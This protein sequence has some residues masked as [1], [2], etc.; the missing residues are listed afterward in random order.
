MEQPQ[1]LSNSTR[2]Y[3]KNIKNNDVRDIQ[4]S[5]YA[6]YINIE[7]SKKIK[8]N[9]IRL[10]NDLAALQREAENNRKNFFTQKGTIKRSAAYFSQ[11]FKHFTEILNGSLI[12]STTKAPV[13]KVASDFKRATKDNFSALFLHLI[14]SILGKTNDITLTN[15]KT[16]LRI[17]L[18]K[19]YIQF[20]AEYGFDNIKMEQSMWFQFSD[21]I[22]HSLEKAGIVLVC[23]KLG[24]R[25]KK[26]K[27]DYIA[28]SEAFKSV[29]IVYDYKASNMPLISKPRDWSF[30]DNVG[31]VHGGFLVGKTDLIVYN[32]EKS[33]MTRVGDEILS[34]INYLQ[35]I[36]YKINRKYLREIKKDFSRFLLEKGFTIHNYEDI[37]DFNIKSGVYSERQGFAIYNEE[38]RAI[39]KIIETIEQSIYLSNFPCF[40]FAMYLD[41]RTR[42]YYHSYPLNPQGD[43]LSRELLMF[44]NQRKKS[45]THSLDVSASG[46]QII[47][48]LLSHAEYLKKTNF[49]KNNKEIVHEKRDLY[50]ETLD[51]YLSEKNFDNERYKQ[52][53][54]NFF[55]RKVFKSIIMCYFYNETHFGV[56]KKLEALGRRQRE[57]LGFNVNIE[58]TLIRK[59]LKNEFQE[60]HLLAQII[61]QCVESS[62]RN[63]KAISLHKSD[64]ETFQYYGL[65]SVTRVDYY[66]RFGKRQKISISADADPLTLDKRKTRR[67]TMPNF[68]HNLDSQLLHQVVT[69]AKESGILLTVI[70]DCF[71]VNNKHKLKIKKWYYDAFNNLILSET[72]SILISFL[73]RNLSEFEY[74]NSVGLIKNLRLRQKNFLRENYEMSPFILTE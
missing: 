25:K 33:L 56:M 73:Q 1:Y 20:S 17:A 67:A 38:L 52:A 48:G 31:G 29:A 74:A 8:K 59:F 14:C 5:I 19:H 13:Q 65:Q 44:G 18:E 7:N 71:I 69:K 34:N 15:C 27:V 35:Q 12:S 36:P 11:E 49:I 28:I 24:P 37:Y 70:H 54:K 60:Y 57:G 43:S 62:I 64:V 30:S 32:K 21:L 41:F 23:A 47:G 4:R 45:T 63:H 55:T 26:H 16:Q 6:R 66:D 40:Y 10:G 51:K 46:L 22:I 72:N 58:I 42:S 3:V 9:K 68:I 61:G 39:R 2:K 53:I 50:A